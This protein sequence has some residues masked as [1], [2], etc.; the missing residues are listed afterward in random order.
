MEG[1]KDETD[2]K[3]SIVVGPWG[4]N[5]GTNWDDG[6]YNGIREIT[7]KYDRCID[8]ICVVYDKN[9]KPVSGLKHGGGGGT[10]TAEI[11]LQFPEEFLIAVTGHYYPVV[12][13]GSPVIRSLMFKSNRRTFGPY[14]VE[15]GTPFFFPM[16]GGQIVGFKGKSGWYLDAIGFHISK[17]KAPKVMQNFQQ[18]F[19]RLTSSLPFA[20]PPRDGGDNRA[21]ST[22]N[23]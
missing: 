5:G 2:E 3:R 11:K 22:I 19:R 13:G 12:R 17:T 14:G 6:F 9:G 16:E 8:L 20:P 7:L 10:K 1:K 4:G 21:K 18:R 15:E 23:S